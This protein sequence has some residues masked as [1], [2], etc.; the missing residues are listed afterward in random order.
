MVVLHTKTLL[1]ISGNSEGVITLGE[2]DD[3]ATIG[4][5]LALVRGDNGDD[6]IT[7]THN[8]NGVELGDGNDT[9]VLGGSL[10]SAVDG[11]VGTDTNRL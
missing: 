10:N 7:I 2:R 6:N 1:T 11:G 3:T 5:A 8:A 4:T 9:V